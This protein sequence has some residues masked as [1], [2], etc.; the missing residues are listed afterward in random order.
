MSEAFWTEL[1]K[2]AQNASG[3]GGAQFTVCAGTH[4]AISI[5]SVVIG[6][7]ENAAT[8]SRGA[9]LCLLNTGLAACT[10][11]GRCKTAEYPRATPVLQHSCGHRPARRAALAP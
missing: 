1:S 7:V 10:I 3:F 4:S 11:T 2:R 9:L 6:A 5:V 8:C